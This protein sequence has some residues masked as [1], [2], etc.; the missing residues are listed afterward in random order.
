MNKHKENKDEYAQYPHIWAAIIN[1]KRRTRIVA[2][3]RKT[4]V[5]NEASA[6][7]ATMISKN[8]L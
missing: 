3:I 8:C 4:G 6:D 7:N 2:L 1:G 5:V